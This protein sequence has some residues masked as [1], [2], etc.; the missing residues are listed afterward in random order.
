[1][2][3]SKNDH[4]IK[5]IENVAREKLQFVLAFALFTTSLRHKINESEVLRNNYG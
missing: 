4:E 5:N 3:K 2:I 1:M